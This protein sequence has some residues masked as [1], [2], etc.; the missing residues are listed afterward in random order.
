MRHKT[1]GRSSHPAFKLRLDLKLW[2]FSGPLV[3]LMLYS[4][5]RGE[6]LSLGAFNYKR[7]SPSQPVKEETGSQAWS[8][9]AKATDILL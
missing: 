3:Y 4:S 5:P 6:Q 8:I 1:W 7:P 2:D 9:S